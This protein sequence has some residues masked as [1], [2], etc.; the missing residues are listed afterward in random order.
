VEPTDTLLPEESPR[1]VVPCPVC[2]GFEAK[3][4]IDGDDNEISVESVGSSR[5]LLSHGRVIRC[6]FCGL[7][8]RSFRPNND[9]L[10]RLYRVADDSTYE[11]EMPNRL[12]TA[13]RHQRIIEKHVRGTGSVLDVGCAS[14]AFLRQMRES[15]WG[16]TGVEP[17]EAQFRRATKVLGD[18]ANIQQC[19]LQEASLQGDFD[20]VTMWD[21]LEHVT[22]PREFLSLAATLLRPGG[23]LVLN[24]PRIDSPAAR[25]L[26]RRWPVLLAEH[27]NYFTVP[28]LR[29]C[30][31]AAGL[32]L[33]HT[34]QRAAAFSL[35]YVLFRAG[36]HYVPGSAV[37]RRLVNAIRISRWSIPIWIGE[38]Y[39]VFLKEQ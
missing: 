27:L 14:G 34:G 24:V 25:L 29:L 22:H 23:S 10:S 4:Y 31:E 38:V 26:G 36:Q 28:S 39:A 13:R 30:G 20:L 9:Q 6:S 16:V 32:R 19:V 8:Y 1:T 15:G 18:N 5:T 7:A 17:S 2:N 3:L 12:R 35:D 11:A 33:A 21:V 37:A